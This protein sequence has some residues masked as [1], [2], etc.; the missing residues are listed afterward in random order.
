[1][2]RGIGCTEWD[3]V[4]FTINGNAPIPKERVGDNPVKQLI[5]FWQDRCIQLGLM[6][7]WWPSNGLINRWLERY[8]FDICKEAFRRGLRAFAKKNGGRLAQDKEEAIYQMN[9]IQ[10]VMR[11][12]KE[13]I[14]DEQAFAVMA[15]A[16]R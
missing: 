8:G 6:C 16:A 7:R 14:E 1:M 11:C 4:Q 13:S 5:A 12:V 10:K 15:A 2:N 9:Y 3:V